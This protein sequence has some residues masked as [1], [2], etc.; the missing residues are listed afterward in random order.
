MDELINDQFSS[1]NIRARQ[2]RLNNSEHESSVDSESM[3][4]RCKV[5]E[6]DLPA[7]PPLSSGKLS[8]HSDDGT[9]LQEFN[10]ME[11]SLP[12]QSNAIRTSKYNLLTFLPLNIMH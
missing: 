7:S 11:D 4:E 8:D 10:V 6:D 12:L 3:Y 9:N 5:L 1:D 2:L